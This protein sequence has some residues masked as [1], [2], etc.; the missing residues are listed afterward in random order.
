MLPVSV[1]GRYQ[2]IQL[3]ANLNFAESLLNDFLS[4]SQKDFVANIVYRTIEEG[5][6]F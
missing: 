5:Y 3:H 6:I 1:S 2:N 4:N